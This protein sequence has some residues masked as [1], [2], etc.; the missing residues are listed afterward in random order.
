MSSPSGAFA[1]DRGADRAAEGGAIDTVR[2]FNRI[3]TSRIGALEDHY[4]GSARSLGSSRVLW[5][6]GGDGREVR[7]IRERSSLL[8]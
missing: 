1:A 5:E 7:E 2:A 8:R 6:V 4:L 3:V